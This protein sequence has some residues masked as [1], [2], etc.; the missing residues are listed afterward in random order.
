MYL[1]MVFKCDW[2][3][4]SY[5]SEEGLL[6]HKKFCKKKPVTVGRSGGGGDAG[7]SSKRKK[8]HHCHICGKVS[9]SSR[10]LK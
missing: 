3:S 8:S 10:D 6:K 1:D 7:S 9:G 4:L 2:C 5:V